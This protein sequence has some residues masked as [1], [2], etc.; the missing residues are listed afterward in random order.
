QLELGAAPAPSEHGYLVREQPPQAGDS[1]RWSL[2]PIVTVGRAGGNAIVV[3][4]D[5]ASGEHARIILDGGK[6]WLE[7]RQSRNGTHL[8]EDRIMRR[9]ILA[10]GDVIGIGNYR[11]RI[12][13][14][15]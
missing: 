14:K 9:T 13:L 15:S 12:H 6:W 1:E 10:D 11:F 5:F 2:Q 7:D 3:N 8:N 4:D